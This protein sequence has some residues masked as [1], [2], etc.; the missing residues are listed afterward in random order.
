MTSGVCVRAGACANAPADSASATRESLA[1]ISL[2]RNGHSVDEDRAARAPAAHQHVGPDRRDAAEH[3][4][5]VAGDGD[6]L[7][8]V[9]NYAALDPVARR[10][11]RIV[12][13][14]EVDALAEELGHQ[15]SGAHL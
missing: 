9:A 6:L 13:G 10:A 2:P 3:V 7:H 15:Q 5:Q 12:A 11:A 4:A 14:N 8:G 1:C